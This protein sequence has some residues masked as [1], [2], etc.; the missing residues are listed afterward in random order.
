MD[1]R[2]VSMRAH[3]AFPRSFLRQR[4]PVRKEQVEIAFR[5]QSGPIEY[6]DSRKAR[7][8]MSRPLDL[9]EAEAPHRIKLDE[10]MPPALPVCPPFLVVEELGESETVKA[11]ACRGDAVNMYL[12]L[13]HHFIAS[14]FP[15]RG[16]LYGEEAFICSSHTQAKLLATPF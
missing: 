11:V 12:A 6:K 16:R 7:D 13:D 10:D 8:S 2:A 9:D 1:A 5:R 4:C 15:S 14:T 3:S